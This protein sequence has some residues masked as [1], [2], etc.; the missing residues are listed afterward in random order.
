MLSKDKIERINDLARKKKEEGLTE[1]EALEQQALRKEYIAAVRKNLKGQLDR[2]EI[3]DDKD[4]EDYTEEE[5]RHIAELSEKLGKEYEAQ[6]KAMEVTIAGNPRKPQGEAG[7]QM[8]E[9]MNESHAAMTEW[10]LNKLNLEANDTVLDVGCGG[11]AALKAMA[12]QIEDG[13]LYGIDYSDVSIEA[14]EELNDETIRSGKMEIIK[15]SVSDLPFE[16]AFFDKIITIESYY[17]WPDFETDMKEIYRVLKP[18]GRFLLVAEMYLADDIDEKHLA[19]SRKFNLRNLTLEEF[20][21]A[22]EEAGYAD[23]E[24]Y[25]QEGNFWIC[26]EGNKN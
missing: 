1:E 18:G 25:T 19:M 22:F 5:K 24:I 4:P 13:K 26:V 3:V 17:F 12:T 2:I 9:R 21:K 10:A 6:N 23:I 15:A 16:D 11:G 7:R 14:S 8:V 20:E